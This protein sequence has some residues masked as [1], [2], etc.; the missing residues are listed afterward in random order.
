MLE[1]SITKILTVELIYVIIVSHFLTSKGYI[2]I[3][4]PGIK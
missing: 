2:E 1:K 3:Y 4:F